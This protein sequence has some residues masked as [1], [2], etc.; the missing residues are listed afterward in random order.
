MD[1][2]QINALELTLSSERFGR[3]LSW[4]EGDRA[5]AIHLYTMNCRLSESLYTPL[6]MLE[7][8]LRNRIHDVASTLVAGNKLAWFDLAQFQ[9]GDRQ[10]E[11]LAKAKSDLTSDRKPVEPSRIVASLTFGYWTSFFSRDYENLW[12]Q[13]L[14]RI[15]RRPNGKGLQRKDFAQPLMPLRLL[16]NRIAHHEPI[17]GWDLPKHYDKIIELAEW[18]SPAGAQWCRDNSRFP[19]LYPVEGIALFDGVNSPTPVPHS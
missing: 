4:A 8:A 12:Q 18:L 5:R 17:I 1:E 10:A 2:A 11:Q 15:A 7:V 9:R 13:G 14:H 19:A 3:Y 16:R 6:H